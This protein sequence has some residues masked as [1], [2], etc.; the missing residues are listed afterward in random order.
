VLLELQEFWKLFPFFL[1]EIQFHLQQSKQLQQRLS[2]YRIYLTTEQAEWNA[3]MINESII[4]FLYPKLRP[5]TV[6]PPANQHLVKKAKV[7]Y[8]VPN[9]TAI[10]TRT[11]NNP[12]GAPLTRTN[13][14][15]RQTPSLVK[16]ISSTDGASS[17]P[18]TNTLL[19]VLNVQQQGQQLSMPSPASQ[20]N[21]QIVN[22]SPF[23]PSSIS[24]DS[25]PGL[26]SASSSS[27]LPKPPGLEKPKKR[28]NLTDQSTTLQRTASQEQRDKQPTLKES[29]SPPI[30]CPPSPSTSIASLAN[31]SIISN[32]TTNNQFSTSNTP[33][34]NTTAANA[35]KEKKTNSGQ[36]KLNKSNLQLHEHEFQQQQQNHPYLQNG[37]SKISPVLLMK[38][39]I[40]QRSYSITDTS[41][42]SVKTQLFFKDE[43]NYPSSFQPLSNTKLFDENKIVL[44]NREILLQR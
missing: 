17:V 18:A 44:K 7:S 32:P 23:L 31:L 42:N 11:A 5:L 21:P 37:N 38:T 3:F 6:P 8:N 41:L 1:T 13:S 33:L 19:S 24:S 34:P 30:P 27:A 25:F 2:L 39:P 36:K 20:V 9:S 10:N 29:T 12:T 35:N 40:R 4:S 26:P 16:R 15:K 22:K 14:I 28:I 43:N